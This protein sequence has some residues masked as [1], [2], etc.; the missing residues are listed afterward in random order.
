M[1]KQEQQ[2]NQCKMNKEIGKLKESGPAF[3]KD[4]GPA[5]PKVDEKYNPAHG[6]CYE[7][8]GGMSLRDW[9]AT[10]APP[11]ANWYPDSWDKGT[12]G[13][14]DREQQLKFDIQWRYVFSDAMLKER[15]SG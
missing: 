7:Y 8:I 15:K 3:P 4:G 5:F 13:A 14:G 1:D 10:F 11:R 9:F 2:Q 6:Q 12:R